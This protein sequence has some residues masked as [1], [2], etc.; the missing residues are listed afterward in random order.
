MNRWEAISGIESS[1]QLI[2][3]ESSRESVDQIL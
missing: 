2:G 3:A 1:D